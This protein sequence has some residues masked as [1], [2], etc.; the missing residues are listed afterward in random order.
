MTL[1]YHDH[2]ETFEA[3]DI[4]YAPPS[5][6]PVATAGTESVWFSPTKELDAVMAVIRKNHELMKAS[7]SASDAPRP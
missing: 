4:C 5:H 2:E 1:R 3:G 6:L 7:R